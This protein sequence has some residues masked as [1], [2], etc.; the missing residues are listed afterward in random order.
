[1]LSTET[2]LAALEERGIKNK[3][4]ERVTG[5]GPVEVSRLRTGKRRL[6]FDEGAALMQAF[7]LLTPTSAPAPDVLQ[8]LV[9][10]LAAALRSGAS[11]EIVRD[12]AVELGAA[13]TFLQTSELRNSPEALHGFLHGVAASR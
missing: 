10:H 5:L 3:D 11:D 6:L 8:M 1:M 9:K 2:I 7:D 13:L 4:I 12:A